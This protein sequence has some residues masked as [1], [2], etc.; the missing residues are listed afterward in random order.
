[1]MRMETTRSPRIE[2]AP[3][4]FR[5]Q[6]RGSDAMDWDEDSSFVIKQKQHDHRLSLQRTL[7]LDTHETDD[8]SPVF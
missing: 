4:S 5:K 1:M 2:E 6:F 3:Q 7:A 8:D